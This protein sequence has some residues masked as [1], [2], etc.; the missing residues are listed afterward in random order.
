[1]GEP[2]GQDG[3][4]EIAARFFEA[5]SMSEAD[6][7]SIETPDGHHWIDRRGIA[8]NVAKLDDAP[9]RLRVWWD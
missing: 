4:R 6:E 1:M 8:F 7:M 9:Y 5:A 3:M 2:I